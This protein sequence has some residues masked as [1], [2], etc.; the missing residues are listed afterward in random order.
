MPDYITDK[1]QRGIIGNA[2]FSDLL[3][4]E[5]LI[6]KGGYWIDATVL[7]TDSKMLEFIDK[8]PLFLYSFYYF[9][10]NP[11]IMELNNW[12]IKSCTNNNILCLLRELLYTY[13][14]ENDRAKDYFLTQLFLTMA[15][16]YYKEE[17]N[18]MPIVSQV[19]SH[20]LATYIAEP[21]DEDKYALLKQTT[22]FHKL[23]TR[24][25]AESIQTKD[26]FYDVVINRGEY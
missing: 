16:E 22:G 4:L 6:E 2:H 5:L 3:R 21:Y 26:C 11:E 19:D 8:Q 18:R 7:C 12:F 14:A 24:F 1:W 15:V 23:S 10:F 25:E 13:W 20:I 9:G 17:Y